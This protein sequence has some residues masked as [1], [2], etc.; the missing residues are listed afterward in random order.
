MNDPW[1]WRT[2]W[3]FTVGVGVGVGGGR[4]REKNKDK[5]N[6]I[7]IKMISKIE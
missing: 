7:I 6:R 4:Q 3:E 1:T 5:Y 2:V